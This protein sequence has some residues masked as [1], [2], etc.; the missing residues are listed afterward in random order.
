M[1]S[2][3]SDLER[4]VLAAVQHDIP[5]SLSPY[6][7]V[8]DEIGISCEQLL[9]I[10]RQWK[11]EG[12]IRRL[13]AIVN[14]FQ[15]GHGIGAMVVW[16]VPDER[17]QHIGELFASFPKVSHAYQRPSRKQWPYNLYT[18]VHASS[19]E[20]L[21]QTIRTMSQQSGVA[22]YRDLKTVKELKK[23][24]PTYVIEK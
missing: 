11:A 23:V 16:S 24:P 22:D 8:A 19:K 14:H 17:V 5:M 6:R 20:E 1:Q 12:K 10:L 3:L 2:D 21:E 18:M 9:D 13:G 15:M 7:D 4:R